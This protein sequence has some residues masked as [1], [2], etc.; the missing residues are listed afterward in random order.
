G[1]TVY[2]HSGETTGFRHI[3]LRVPEQDLVISLFTNRDDLKIA[4][5]F[6]E[7]MHLMEIEIAELNTEPLYTWL[8]RVYADQLGANDY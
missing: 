6:D 8:S 7:V 2:F 3:F 4:E 5:L 1:Q